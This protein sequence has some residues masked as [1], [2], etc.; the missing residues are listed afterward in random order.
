MVG[1]QPHSCRS[2]SLEQVDRF[3]YL[4][5]DAA[6]H[7]WCGGYGGPLWREAF[8]AAHV[9]EMLSAE[10]IFD[11]RVIKEKL[12]RCAADRGWLVYAPEPRSLR[13]GPTFLASTCEKVEICEPSAIG[14]RIASSVRG[15]LRRHQ[16]FPTAHDFSMFIRNPDGTHLF[17]SESQLV[18]SLPWLTVAGWIAYERG[19]IRCGSAAI[20]DDADRAFR[21]HVKRENRLRARLEAD[22]GT[23][24]AVQQPSMQVLPVYN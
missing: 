23:G 10:G 6:Y 24:P 18:K 15:F 14:R 1:A 4:I 20:A 8:E 11:N 16:R 5:A 21:H 17:R 3:G 19:Q 2:L 9:S 7:R 22:L 13:F 12:M